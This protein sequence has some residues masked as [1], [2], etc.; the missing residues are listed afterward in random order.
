MWVWVCV[1]SS[2]I[3]ECKKCAYKSIICMYL[4]VMIFDFNSMT[5]CW[6]VRKDIK[7]IKLIQR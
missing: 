6:H 5:P 1:C 3:Y 4:V 2:Y 7:D